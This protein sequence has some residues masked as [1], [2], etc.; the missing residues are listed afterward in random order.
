MG[1]HVSQLL[2]L[3]VGAQ[4]KRPGGQ[5]SRVL[6]MPKALTIVLLLQPAQNPE[7]P[8]FWDFQVCLLEVVRKLLPGPQ[9]AYGQLHLSGLAG[10]FLQLL[11]VI[12]GEAVPTQLS[13]AVF[14][15]SSS[16]LTVSEPLFCL[17]SSGTGTQAQELGDMGFS[18]ISAINSPSLLCFGLQ[19][20][21]CQMVISTLSLQVTGLLWASGFLGKMDQS[22]CYR[23]K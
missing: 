3:A 7:D 20:P 21:L 12:A 14:S 17:A 18:P 2:G 10:A 16:P 4:G 6:T 11:L 19:S 9:P 8:S 13:L 22:L 5:E 1:N 23:I 15:S